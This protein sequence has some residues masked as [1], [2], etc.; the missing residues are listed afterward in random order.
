MDINRK[1][2]FDVLM[3]V[4]KNGAY[5]NLSLNNFIERNRPDSPAFVRELVYGVLK[6]KMLL[7]WFLKQ[8]VPSG[9][10]KVK[11]QDLM[12]LRMG[13]YQISYMDSVPEYAA[14]SETVDMAKKLARGREGFINGVLRGYIRSR[15]SLKT[16]ERGADA[17]EYLAVVYSMEKWIV[18]LWID[19]YGEEKAEELLRASNETPELSI[20]VNLMKTDRESL[21][22]E[23]EAA[24]FQ[25]EYSVISRRGLLVKG[26]GLLESE[27]YKAGKFSVQ[28]EASILAS[29]ML[30]AE[31]GDSVADVCAAPGGKTFATAE[32]MAGE[33]VIYAM[34]K[35]EHKLKLMETQAKRAGIDNIRLLCRDS[36]QPL[37]ELIGRMDKVLA[38][39][40]CSGL[41]VMRRK[42]EIKYKGK[43]ELDELIERQQQILRAAADYV[44]DGGILVY[45]T[46]TVNP[47]ENEEQIEK[48]LRGNREFKALEQKQLLPGGGTDGFFICRMRKEQS[49]AGRF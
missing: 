27:I 5:S 14:V 36:R 17:A 32:L 30:G 21:K 2:A 19:A 23:L 8:L 1:T 35:Y 10:K 25:A 12:L 7:D 13:I 15:D 6:N 26:S 43:Q 4:E 29:D 18:Q 24:G 49:N 34:D 46:C 45:S 11:V 41:G 39:V 20:R 33:G 16:P 37:D 47:W 48:F 28:D 40:P 38:D 3:D 42:P 22:K 9:L 44:A 31:P